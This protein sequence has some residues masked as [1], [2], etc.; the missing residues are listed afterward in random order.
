ML[1]FK[2]FLFGELVED[3]REVFVNPL[4]LLFECGVK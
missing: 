1:R 2:M 4:A 3:S